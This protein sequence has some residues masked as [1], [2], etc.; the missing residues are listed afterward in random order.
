MLVQESV[1]A[2]GSVSNR[3][4]RTQYNNFHLDKVHLCTNRP[5]HQSPH[6]SPDVLTESFEE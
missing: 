3:F 4:F 6:V 2:T 1:H 5:L